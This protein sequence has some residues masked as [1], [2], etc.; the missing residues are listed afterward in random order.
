MYKIFDCT[1][2]RM[3]KYSVYYSTLFT[4]CNSFIRYPKGIPN[5]SCLIV[6]TKYAISITSMTSEARII[7]LLKQHLFHVCIMIGTVLVLFFCY[8]RRRLHKIISIKF[9]YSNILQ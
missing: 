9:V 6:C 4:V 7:K 1:S 3:L 2:V 5:C 8:L